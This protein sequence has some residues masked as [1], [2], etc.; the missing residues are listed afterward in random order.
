[1]PLVI[2]DP[3]APGSAKGRRISE[4]ALS[5][6]IPETILE[7]AGVSI[8][9]V[10][11][12]RSL[13]PLIRGERVADWRT[14]FF[15]EHLCP[16]PTIPKSQGYRTHQ[17]KYI[18]YTEHPEFEELYDLQKNPAE[19]TNLAKDPKFASVMAEMRRKCDAGA[20]AAK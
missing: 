20:Q 9:P 2:C 5:L 13:V 18:R 15:Y 11:Q 12:G 3:R 19:T 4:D 10:M 8:P 17:W 16:I 7:L 6:D 1:M 14:E